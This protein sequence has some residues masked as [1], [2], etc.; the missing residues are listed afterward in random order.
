M[1]SDSVPGDL[2]R[3][4]KNVTGFN[5]QTFVQA[6]ESQ[7]QVVSVRINP[8]KVKNAGE[9]FDR[10]T[11]VPWST[12]GYYL[13]QRPSFILDPALHGGAYYVQEA[14][15]MFL[16]QCLMQTGDLHAAINV[17]DLC[18]APGGKSTLLQSLISFE[19]LLVSNEVIKSRAAV[20][21]ENL[22]KWGGSNVIIT[23]N[24][25]RDFSRLPAFFDVMVV[26]APCS[27]SGLFRRDPEA[28]KEWSRDA[29]HTCSLRQQRILADAY[30]CLKQNG[31][32]IYSTCSYSPE[33]DER[34]ADWLMSNYHLETVKIKTDPGWNIIECRSETHKAYGYRFFPDKLEGE[35]LYIACFI[36]KDGSQKEVFKTKKPLIEKASPAERALAAHWVNSSDPLSFYRHKEQLFALPAHLEND[37]FELRASMNIK[38]AGVA[39]GKPLKDELLPDHELA[40]AGI[41]SDKLPV[42]SLK[43][44]DA[45]QYLRKEEVTVAGM[46]KGWALVQYNGLNLGWVKVL[47]SRINNYYPKEWRILKTGNA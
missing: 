7:R 42:I 32:L 12:M 25:P 3:S 13:P 18:A 4:L 31:V 38:K 24:D 2:L 16:E 33:E 9:L 41:V 35:G 40:L 34:I 29:V 17:L 11:N 19:S 30:D 43:K 22:T 21:I 45:L 8:H 36:K 44:E 39:I 10:H 6:H 5:E 27:G 1:K 14:S 28:I 23:N 26:D 47:S 20:L 15:G 46:H 37:L